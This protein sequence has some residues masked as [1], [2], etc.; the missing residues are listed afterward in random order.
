MRRID[1]KPPVALIFVEAVERVIDRRHQRDDFGRYVLQWQPRAAPV[2]IDFLGL[3]GSAIKAGKGSAH[4]HGRCDQRGQCHQRDDGQDKTQKQRQG[5]IAEPQ[6][7]TQL[8]PAPLGSDVAGGRVDPLHACRGAHA[9]K[10]VPAEPRLAD[11]IERISDA[12]ILQRHPA[13]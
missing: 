2:D 8:R 6:A 5:R 4:H 11:P 9:V 3:R 12:R 13:L 1:K 10:H 7:A